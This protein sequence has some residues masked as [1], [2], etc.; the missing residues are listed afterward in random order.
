[1]R[2]KLWGCDIDKNEIQERDLFMKKRMALLSALLG[3]LG[4]VA[5]MA[6]TNV[7]H[8]QALT[9]LTLDPPAPSF[10]EVYQ[11]L[12]TNLEGVSADEL[13]G[14][15]VQGLIHQ[16]E[17]RVSLAAA[18]VGSLHSLP[19]ADARVFDSS[20]AYFRI[21]TVTSNLPEAFLAAYRQMNETNKSKLRGLVLDL[22]FADGFDYA[23]AAKLA[24]CFLSSDHPLL[25]WQTASAHANAFRTCPSRP[26]RRA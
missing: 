7:Y 20:F 1:L 4:S 17:P 14:A 16:L 18:T 9:H 3:A 15:A 22:R 26:S 11:L 13:N 8:P 24:D 23:A 21:A 6:Q 19:L 2:P 25:E 10:H 5:A 12:S